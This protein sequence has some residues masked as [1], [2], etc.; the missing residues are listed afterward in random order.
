M[1]GMEK[2]TVVCG[3][4]ITANF[5]HDCALVECAGDVIADVELHNCHLNVLGRILV[6]KGAICGGSYT[7]LGGIETKKVGSASSIK[8]TL[9]AGFDYRDIPELERIAA[10]LEKNS[11]QMAQTSSFQELEVLRAARAEL[12]EVLMAIRGRS[13]ENSNPKINVKTILYDNSFIRIGLN[14][15]EKVDERDGPFSVIEN[16][17]EGGL[18]FL[19]MTS[20][21]VRACDIELAF[22][23]ENAQTL[24][25]T[26]G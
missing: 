23:R 8:T 24:H 1:D 2:G 14:A 4:S 13:A 20:L 3:G 15:K 5:M 19:S 11:T 21:D 16:T 17:I 22:I 6:N 10:A 26:H 9:R 12:T 25:R 18:R 7:A